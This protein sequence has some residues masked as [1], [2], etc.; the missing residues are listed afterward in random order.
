MTSIFAMST[1][2]MAALLC[3]GACA[4]RDNEA[5]EEEAVR[6]EIPARLQRDGSIALSDADRTALGLLVEPARPGELIA[7][8]LRFGRVQARLSEDGVIVAPVAGRIP[9]PAA[10][11]LGAQVEQGAPVVDIVPVLAAAERLSAS[12]RGAE[13]AGE[14]EA[15]ERAAAVQGDEAARAEQLAAAQIVSR[16]KL[17]ETRN[18]LATSQAQLAALR[19]ARGIQARGEGEALSLRAE[20]TGIV[21]S[22]D[23]LVG[24]LVAA[25]TV[26]ARIL[27]PGPL[28]IDVEILPDEAVGDR[29]EVAVAGRFV[30]ARLLARGSVVA[31]DGFR[32]DRLEIDAA[33][34]PGL[35]PGAIAEVR[36]GRGSSSGVVVPET[37]LVSSARGEAVFVERA[38]G[39]YLQRAVRVTRRFGGA[40]QIEAGLAVGEAVVVRGAQALRGESLR[41]EL[42]ERD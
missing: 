6:S 36:V 4:E 11:E 18:A 9:H 22:I 20:V 29:Y 33:L 28:W 32:R 30:P 34:A 12:V 8:V 3:A 2:A 25:G 1:V 24:A 13:L 10:V 14:I 26:L 7:S 21:A 31:D 38:P 42:Q 27:K 23:A 39:K 5:E 15:L 35:L 41:D 40:A 16:A 37:A 19:K 17:Q